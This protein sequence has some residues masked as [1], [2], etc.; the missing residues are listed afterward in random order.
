MQLARLA[1]GS[2]AVRYVEA[3][4]FSWQPD[5]SYGFVFFGFWL[6]HVPRSR[7]PGFW[8]LLRACLGPGGHFFFVDNLRSER[9]GAAGQQ[10]EA[11]GAETSRRRLH[12]GREFEIVKIF[13]EPAALEAELR[14]QG[15]DAR[16]RSTGEF[17]LYGSGSRRD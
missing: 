14:R 4:L 17:F 2:D 5:G 16:V 1:V 13:Y 3:D 8:D 15:W 10:P 9:P 11:P 6:S 7:L 12:D